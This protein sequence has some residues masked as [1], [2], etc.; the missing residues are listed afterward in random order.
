M[1]QQNNIPTNNAPV[2]EKI[3]NQTVNE[4]NSLN[5]ALNATDADG[6]ILTYSASNL[7]TGAA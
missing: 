1:V 3:E 6:D 7:P 4:G 2:M 5:F